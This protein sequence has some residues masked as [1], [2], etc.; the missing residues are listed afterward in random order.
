M[1]EPSSHPDTLSRK[2][3]LAGAAGVVGAVSLG[4]VV[5]ASAGGFAPSSDLNSAA[6]VVNY[7]SQG[8]YEMVKQ[9]ATWSKRTGTTVKTTSV[10]KL[11]TMAPRLKSPAGKGVDVAGINSGY[12]P[13]YTDIHLLTPLTPAKLP[14]LNDLFPFFKTDRRLR[15]P[16]GSYKGIPYNW[17]PLGIM[18]D[19]SKIARPT[20]YQDLLTPE[21]K[22]KFAFLDAGD[23]N[24]L[25]GALALGINSARNTKADLDRIKTFLTGVVRNAKTL[26]N[27]DASTIALYRA[28]EISASVWGWPGYLTLGLGL[29]MATPPGTRAFVDVQFIPPTADNLPGAY[30]FLQA[31]TAGPLYAQALGEFA[32][33]ATSQK[34]VKLLNKQTRSLVPYGQI[35]QFYKGLVVPAGLT[36]HGPYLT[37][38]D[39]IAA[40][41]D[42]KVHA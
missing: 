40:W 6:G 35:A 36:T 8:G 23:Q 22:G 37:I 5:K 38:D 31:T 16:D 41:E 15:F 25:F 10:G 26:T 13:Q 39:A 30:A 9:I 7:Y 11:S 14:A 19:P 4:N 21:W 33:F 42:I 18:Y 1:I 32:G 20:S 34:T 2:R 24:I 17:G 28:G 29:K 3:F 12:L 27:G